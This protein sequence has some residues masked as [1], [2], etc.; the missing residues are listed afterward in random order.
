[1]HSRNNSVSFKDV[2]CC[3]KIYYVNI[4]NFQ[5]D[6]YVPSEPKFGWKSFDIIVFKNQWP[7]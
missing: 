7:T 4:F 2:I 1:M 5:I 6:L 3:F